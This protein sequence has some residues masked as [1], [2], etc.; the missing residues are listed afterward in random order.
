MLSQ[1]SPKCFIITGYRENVDGFSN[2]S[3]ARLSDIAYFQSKPHSASLQPM[4]R[5]LWR[6]LSY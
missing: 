6:R 1:T 5:S 4:S 3:G 2:G